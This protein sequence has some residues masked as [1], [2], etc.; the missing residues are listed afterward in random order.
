M[1]SPCGALNGIKIILFL[2][3]SIELSLIK[4]GFFRFLE[5]QPY[6]EYLI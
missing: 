1:A 5:K 3:L 2:R 6:L 4:Q